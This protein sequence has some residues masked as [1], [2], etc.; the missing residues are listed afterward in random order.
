MGRVAIIGDVGGHPDQLRR[1]LAWLGAT[2]ERL[3]PDLTVIQV[4]DLVDRGPDSTG[5][6]DIVANLLDDG[7][8]IQLAGNH[9]APARR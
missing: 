7:R 2:G 9:E 5:V 3:P 4:G 8:W 6:L 1:A